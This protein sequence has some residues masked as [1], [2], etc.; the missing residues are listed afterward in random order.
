MNISQ[1]SNLKLQSKINLEKTRN[2]LKDP[3]YTNI[4]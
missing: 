3:S 2:F 4:F 1:K